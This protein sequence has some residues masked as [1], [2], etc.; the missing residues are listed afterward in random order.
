MPDIH[1]MHVPGCFIHFRLVLV[2]FYVLKAHLHLEHCISAPR[3][4]LLV[5]FHPEATQFMDFKTLPWCGPK[6]IWTDHQKTNSKTYPWPR[7]KPTDI[8]L[9]PKDVIKRG[10]WRQSHIPRVMSPN[11]VYANRSRA[12]LSANMHVWMHLAMPHTWQFLCP[13]EA[14]AQHIAVFSRLTQLWRK[15]NGY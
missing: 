9:S 2:W 10:I 3:A 14:M 11:S 1:A 5:L 6:F 7:L 15:D 12:D 13:A 8:C 4:C